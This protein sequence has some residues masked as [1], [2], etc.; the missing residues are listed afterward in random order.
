M[1]IINYYDIF[2][3]AYKKNDSVIDIMKI[4]PNIT[5]SSKEYDIEHFFETSLI[6]TD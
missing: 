2:L 1:I 5:P 3:K 4:Y 6:A